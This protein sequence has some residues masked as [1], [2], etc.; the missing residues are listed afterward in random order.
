MVWEH[1]IYESNYN[2]EAQ[3]DSDEDYENYDHP[4]HIDDW[5]DTYS[6]ELEYMWMI[7]RRYLGDA[8]LDNSIMNQACFEDFVRFVH[9][10][11]TA[12]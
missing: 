10:H 6:N 3:L 9:Q 7:L 8:H 4:L 5:R 12:Q 11:S 1:Y 2:T